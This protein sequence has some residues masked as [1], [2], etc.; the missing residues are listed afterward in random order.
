MRPWLIAGFCALIASPAS[1]DEQPD[2]SSDDPGAELLEFLGSWGDDD[3]TW[4]E[5]IDA[6]A[7]QNDERRATRDDTEPG[8][9]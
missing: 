3:D 1:G 7:T 9:E 6:A 8:D 4:Q 5:M 2:A